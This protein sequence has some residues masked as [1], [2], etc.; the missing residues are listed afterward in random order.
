M[1]VKNAFLNGDLIEEVYMHPPPGFSPSS[2]KI[3]RLHRVLYGPQQVPC[4]WYIKFSSTICDLGFYASAYDS[5]LFILQ[6]AHGIV[7]LFLYVD[8]MIITG[9]DAHSISELKDFLHRNF[10]IK[11][12]GP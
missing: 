5:A 12:L 9:D 10:E 3:C 6:S 7:L 11:D 8:D 2:H 1:Y 4:A